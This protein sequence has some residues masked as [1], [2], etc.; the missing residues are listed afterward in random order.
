MLE[1]LLGMSANRLSSAVIEGRA[2]DGT[3]TRSAFED[4]FRHILGIVDVDLLFGVETICRE[5]GCNATTGM[6]VFRYWLTG[7]VPCVRPLVK[8]RERFFS[9]PE[10]V[11]QSADVT[12]RSQR[13]LTL[14]VTVSA[15]GKECSPAESSCGGSMALSHWCDELVDI[16]VNRQ[17]SFRMRVYD[18]GGSAHESFDIEP[19]WIWSD[20]FIGEAP[21]IQVLFDV[22]KLYLRT[23][24]LA[25]APTL[26]KVFPKNTGLLESDLC[27]ERGS[28]VRL[29]LDR[30][31]LRSNCKRLDIYEALKNATV[32][33]I[34]RERRTPREILC[35]LKYGESMRRRAKN[36]RQQRVSRG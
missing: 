5:Y 12:V 34:L 16:P 23:G 22:E 27:A 24:R 15:N 20:C 9:L 8:Y 36:T 17:L 14:W 6:I 21:S 19:L 10:F 25:I 29:L 31:K 33:Y 28:A 26:D 3:L 7:F 4:E 11:P 2:F 32:D 30:A 35:E 18:E 1:N 13:E